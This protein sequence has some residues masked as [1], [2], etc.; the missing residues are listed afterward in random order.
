MPHVV[1]TLSGFSATRFT[2]R[3]E[4][5]AGGPTANMDFRVAPGA[6]LGPGLKSGTRAVVVYR[7]NPKGEG[8]QALGAV[9]LPQ[10]SDPKAAIQGMPRLK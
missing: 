6:F 9:A 5:G 1:G 8:Y 2:V 10:G 3:R 7:M 4:V